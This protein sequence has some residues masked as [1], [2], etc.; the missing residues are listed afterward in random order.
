M[1]VAKDVERNPETNKVIGLTLVVSGNH[2][3]NL[4]TALARALNVWPDF[5]PEL[6]DLSDRL[7]HG[8]PLQDYY[9]MEKKDANT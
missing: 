5:P 2:L 1:I 6:M 9:S 3:V 8:R 4:R 7:E